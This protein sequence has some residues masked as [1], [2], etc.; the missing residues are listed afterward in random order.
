MPDASP[1]AHRYDFASDNTAGAC[2]E[3]L[4][5]LAEAS[6]GREPSYGHDRITREAT[7]RVRAVF[8]TDCEVFFVYNGTAAN[9]LALA[10]ICSSYHAILAHADAHVERDEC[11]APE[12]FSGGARVVALPGALGKLSVATVERAAASHHE[13][14]ASKP[15]VLSLTQSTEWGTVYSA[16]EIGAL[17]ATAHRH[18]LAVHLDGARFANATVT[19]RDRTGA[20]PADFTWRAGVDVLSFGGTKNGAAGTEA[21]VFFNRTLAAEFA[22]RRKQSGQL[23]SKMR[24]LAAQWLGLLHDDAWLRHAAQANAMATRLARELSAFPTLRLLAPVEANAVFVELPP[25]VAQG[26]FARGWHFHAMIGEHGYRLM[27]AWD[28]QPADLAAFVADLRA[29][30]SAP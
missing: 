23:A 8:E 24:F 16:D 20:H 12:F 15:R 13:V 1:T 25:P 11:A 17:A 27:G 21:I 22:Y 19:L 6:R 5:A 2:P 10:S 14:H 3:V 4:A 29:V 28:T 26:M 9:A 30:A 18:G 7:A